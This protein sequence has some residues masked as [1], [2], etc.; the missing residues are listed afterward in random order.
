MSAGRPTDYKP[1]FADQ[2][3]KLC[4]LG[5]TDQELG[6]FFALFP[7]EDDWL[8]ACLLLIRQDRRGVIAVQKKTRASNRTRRRSCDPSIRL[9]EAMRARLWAALKGATDGALFSRLDY[10]RDEL[11]SHLEAQFVDGMTWGNYGQW[12]VDHIKPCAAFDHSDSEQFA[13]C[14]GLSNLRPLWGG[15]NISKGAKYVAA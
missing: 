1:E 12:H 3:R 8:V 5:A 14:W 15:D 4:E 9:V 11:V 6:D 13:E 10:S 2:A 7:T